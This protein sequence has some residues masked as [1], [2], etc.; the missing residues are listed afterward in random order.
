MQ[1]FKVNASFKPAGD[2]P[3][4]I[5]NLKKSILSGSPHQT[6]LG[7]TGS[8]KTFT[9][10]KVIEEV[11]K[12]TLVL[13]HNKTLAAQ[14]YGE[15]LDFFPDNAVG[16]FVSYYD[17]YQPEAYLPKTD[18]FIEKDATIND[19]IDKLRHAATRALF[20]RRDVIII[21][22]VSC[23]YGLGSPE[24]YHGMLLFIETGMQIEREH[25]LQKLVRIQY[26]R[27]DVDFQRGTFRVRG[28]T[29]DIVPVYERNEAIRIEFLGD[30]IDR[31]SAFDPLTQKYIREV[32]RI[33]IYPASH[34]VTP[35]ETLER[36]IQ[37]IREELLERIAF[38]ESQNLLIEAQ[39]IEQRTMF[40]LEMI[41]EVG[42]CQGIENYSRHLTNRLEN[43]P[44]PTLL[45]YFPSDSLFMIDESH[46]TIPQLNGMYR[47]DRSRKEKLIRYGFR[48]PSAFDNRPLKF[49]E[50]KNHAK[51]VIYV[52]ATPAQYELE[53]SKNNII[54]LI[55]RPTGLVDPI[56]TIQPIKEQVDD[57]FKEIKLRAKKNQRTLVTT[58]TK[59]FSEDLTEH[60][61]ELGLKVKYL[62]SDIETLER[63]HIIRELRL[64]EF[65]A[66]IGINLLREGLDIPEVSLVAILDA[67]KEGFLRSTTSL[68]QT[69]GRAARN[70]DGKVI[71]YA[72]TIT[73][74]M[75][76]AIDE[77]NRRRII[78][79]EHNTTNKII[80]ESIKKSIQEVLVK[81]DKQAT[82]TIVENEEDEHFSRKDAPKLIKNLEK[83]MR[84]AAKNLEFEKAAELRDRVKRIREKDL[85][86]IT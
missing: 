10:A 52:S 67:D 2:Q 54:E 85:S 24:A 40:D 70:I 74:S 17:Y 86:I 48:L 51:Q 28:D 32:D 22:S 81:Q 15:F 38:F 57:L 63:S 84:A 34:Y 72:D 65:D 26:K 1:P 37:S 43:E 76:K 20:E 68:I 19:E 13:A 46:A 9:L 55:V 44:P 77:M 42:Y 14:L 60:Y 3:A 47:G 83:K 59:R 75:Q 7:V 58:L 11:Q 5:L 69:S 4:A 21:A 61:T 71:F 30:T 18:T 8:G 49:E 25:V 64:G 12:P 56:V 29:V 53:E 78:Q 33:G 35:K 36:A 45:D 16:Y 6:L 79:T 50:F 82:T 41:K 39:R 73:Q 27:N 62:H 31:I 23:I 80:P 66:L